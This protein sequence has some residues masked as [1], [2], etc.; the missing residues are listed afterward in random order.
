MTVLFQFESNRGLLNAGMNNKSDKRHV[1]HI[2]SNLA[3]EG[4][5]ESLCT[6]AEYWP[7]DKIALTVCTFHDGPLR[8]RIEKSGI[9]VKTLCPSR[10]TIANVPLFLV[11]MWRIRRELVRLIETCKIDLIQTHILGPVDFIILSLRYSTR[12]KAVLWTI[13]GDDFLPQRAGRLLR[14]RRLLSRRLYRVLASQVD[15][16]IAV[17]DGVR[18]AIIDQIGS[19]HR[20]VFTIKNGVGIKR[21]QQHGDKKTLCAQLGINEEVNLVLAV[22]RLAEEKG[23]RYLI[24]AVATVVAVHPHTHFLFAGEGALRDEL[25]A[26]AQ[27]TGCLKNIHFLGGRN[28]VPALLAAADLFVLPSLREGLSI[29]L[30]EAMAA[31]KPIVATDVAGS[32]EALNSET[33]VI[34]PPH[35]SPSLAE[36]IGQILGNPAKANALGQAAKEHVITNY[37]AENQVTQY[38]GLYHRL[39]K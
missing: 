8:S 36:K 31:G 30:L 39:L 24:E 23:H 22:G 15:G 26:L 32:N 35:D 34:V 25:E 10:Y 14:V 6:L 9:E 33:G 7:N 19:I 4:A 38:L 12:L 1:M 17:S 16:F 21:F 27:K 3:L 37:S 5:Q 11:E 13:H 18:R 20:K 2:I 28:D 29:A